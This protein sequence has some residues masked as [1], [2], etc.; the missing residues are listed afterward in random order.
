MKLVLDTNVVASAMLW[1]GSP[2][3]LLEAGRQRRITLIS[4]VPMLDELT[5]V[6]ARPKFARKIGESLLDV[7][8]LVDGYAALAVLVRP[9]PLVGVAPDE[10]DDVVIATAVAAQADAVVTGD[11]ALLSVMQ[12]GNVRL[13]TVNEALRRLA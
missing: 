4:S 9:V 12:Y 7:A 8:T 1:G 6:L 5:H 10:D 2:R 13:W 11:K 3:R